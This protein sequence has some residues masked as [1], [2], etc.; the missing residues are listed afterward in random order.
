MPLKKAGSVLA[1]T[2]TAFNAKGQVLKTTTADG[3]VIEYEYNSLGRQ[4][5]TIGHVVPAESVGLA[6]HAG[7]KV[8]LRTGKKST[9]MGEFAFLMMRAR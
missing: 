3:Q 8:R 5:A 2:E 9:V 4:T 6:R 7:T 1:K